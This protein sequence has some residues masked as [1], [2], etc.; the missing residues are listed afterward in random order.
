MNSSNIL[1]TLVSINTSLTYNIEKPGKAIFLMK[2]RSKLVRA[3]R[4][5]NKFPV[6]QRLSADAIKNEEIKE[7]EYQ[8][9]K[10]RKVRETGAGAMEIVEQ[11]PKKGGFII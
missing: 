9:T 6:S 5:V 7:H 1:S 4:N 11:E 3:K 10:R 8:V 2:Q